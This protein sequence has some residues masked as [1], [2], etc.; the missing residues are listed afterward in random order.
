MGRYRLIFLLIL[1][2]L[3]SKVFV[4]RIGRCPSFYEYSNQQA[5]PKANEMAED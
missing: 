4:I 2:I 3:S 1:L 5:R